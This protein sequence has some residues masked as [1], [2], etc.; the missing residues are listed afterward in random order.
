MHGKTSQIFPKGV[1][2]LFEGID[3]AFRGARYHSL[4]LKRETLPDCLRVTALAEDG[5]VMAVEHRDYPVY[6]LQFHPESIL[7]EQGMKFLE[8][9]LKIQG[10]KERTL[11][12]KEA[13]HTLMDGK[14]LDY[15]TQRRLWR[16]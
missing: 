4:A 11:M 14:D 9:F 13:I 8:N 3:G 7:T 16:R 5:E 1:S 10:R 15:G 6:G 2:P 12:I